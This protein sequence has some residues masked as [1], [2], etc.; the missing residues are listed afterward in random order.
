[1]IKNF[2]ILIKKSKY[3][4]DIM[5]QI[6]GNSLAQLINLASLPIITRLYTPKEFGEQT[7]FL[8]VTAIIMT[9]VTLRLEYLI[10]L[11]KQDAEADSIIAIAFALCLFWIGIYLIIITSFY[12]NIVNLIGGQGNEYWILAIPAASLLICISNIML[13]KIQRGANFKIS[14][15][16]E[17]LNKAF[18]AISCIVGAILY[19][20]ENWL[21]YSLLIGYLAKTIYL[22]HY[23]CINEFKKITIIL[24]SSTLAILQKYYQI[25]ISATLSNFLMMIGAIIP[26]VM[27]ERT[28]GGGVLGQY[29]LVTATLSLPTSLMGNAIGQVYFQRAAREYNINGSFN[30]LWKKTSINLLA[31]GLPIYILIFII[32]PLI[33]PTLFGAEWKDTGEFAKYLCVSAFFAFFTTPLDR[34]SLVVKASLYIISWHTSR[35]L[36]TAITCYLAIFNSLEF[37]SFLFLHVSQQ[38]IMYVIDYIAG[39]YFSLP[40]NKKIFKFI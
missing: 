33:Y 29:A 23:F 22:Y 2:A 20:L 6:Y 31:F 30:H 7:Y 38:C 21:V 4:A 1:M 18:F 25:S 3:V 39:C 26:I 37:D 24:K 10:N 19:K 13:F 28:Y 16:S 5:W 27:I 34:G 8:Q 14:G 15:N 11:P 32:S 12:D 40:K 9:V 36:I 35:T 17:I